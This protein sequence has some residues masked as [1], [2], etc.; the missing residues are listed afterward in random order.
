VTF[1]LFSKID[2]NGPGR[3][4]LYAFLT[5]EETTP[6]GP[7][8]IRWNF[9]KFLVDRQGKV[10]ARFPPTTAPASE[11]IVSAVEQQLG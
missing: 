5:S 4:P 11:E 1:P 10:V 8:D 6:D 9:A 7:G 3:D 2:V